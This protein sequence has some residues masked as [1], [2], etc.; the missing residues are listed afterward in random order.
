MLLVVIL[1]SV[2]EQQRGKQILGSHLQ[3]VSLDHRQDG[4][5]FLPGVRRFDSKLR[6]HV[7]P[8]KQHVEQLRLRHRVPPAFIFKGRHGRIVKPALYLFPVLKHGQVL[9]RSPDGKVHRL[10]LRRKQRHIRPCSRKRRL[11]QGALHQHQLHGYP[12]LRGK[13]LVD[14]ILQHLGLV[15]PGAGSVGI[16]VDGGIQPHGDGP[17]LSLRGAHLLVFICKGSEKSGKL[18]SQTLEKSHIRLRGLHIRGLQINVI[19][20]QRLVLHIHHPGAQGADIVLHASQPFGDLLGILQKYS[21]LDLHGV[22]G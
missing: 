20:L 2:L 13:Q 1:S 16:G 8:V 19:Q 10:V 12:R 5:E 21:Q 7:R 3:V 4:V 14:H 15:T 9:E 18:I 6:K 22:Y 17:V 11:D